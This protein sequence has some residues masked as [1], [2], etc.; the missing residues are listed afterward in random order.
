MQ[1]QGARQSAPS[2]APATRPG[3]QA[4][5]DTRDTAARSWPRLRLEDYFCRRIQ[6]SGLVFDRFGTLRRQFVVDMAGDW[7]ARA[8]VLTLDEHFRYSDG[9]TERR[10]WTLARLAGDRWTGRAPDIL[11]LAQGHV[12]GNAFCWTYRLSVP[13]GR[14]AVP[15]FFDDRMYLQPDDTMLGRARMAKWGVTLGTV[16]VAFRPVGSPRAGTAAVDLRT[17]PPGA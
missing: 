5:A 9:G 12:A 10:V 14:H 6:A 4:M 2:P 15:V 11:G 1:A 7:D 13:V 17:R 8:G 3:P 16:S